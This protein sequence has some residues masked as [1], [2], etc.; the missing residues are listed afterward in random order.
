MHELSIALSILE[1]A[2]DEMQARGARKLIA[3]HVKLGALSGVVRDALVSSYQAASEHSPLAGSHLIIEEIPVLLDCPVCGPG[4]RAQS[5]QWL[6]CEN[7]GTPAREIVQG[8][9]LLVSALEVLE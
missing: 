3:V 8:R 2:E 4:K 7:C 9:E 5:L 1:M 6:C